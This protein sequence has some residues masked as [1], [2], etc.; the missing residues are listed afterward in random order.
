ML[1]DLDASFVCPPAGCQAHAPPPGPQQ[2]CGQVNIK[3][4]LA[5]AAGAK[6]A[7]ARW[8]SPANARP[9]MCTE[10]AV[11]FPIDDWCNTGGFR[12]EEPPCL[13]K[14]EAGSLPRNPRG[15]EAVVIQPSYLDWGESALC[16]CRM[17]ALRRS[18]AVLMGRTHLPLTCHFVA[19]PCSAMTHKF[20]IYNKAVQERLWI[21]SV[22][23]DEIQFYPL[24]F[25]RLEVPP[26]G[27][28]TLS[29]VYLPRTLGPVDAS[30]VVETSR[31]SFLVPMHG[32]GVPSPYGVT[33]LSGPKVPGLPCP[34]L[35]APS[36]GS[37]PL[38]LKCRLFPCWGQVPF[39]LYYSYMLMLRNPHEKPLR[40]KEVYTHNS[41]LQLRLPASP[42]ATGALSTEGRVRIL[43]FLL[44]ADLGF[45]VELLGPPAQDVPGPS[46]LWTIEPFAEKGVIMLE[47]KSLLPQKFSGMVTVI[48][49][50]GPLL[51]P[52]DI[53]AIKGGVHANMDGVD[54]GAPPASPLDGSQAFGLPSC[55]WRFSHNAAGLQLNRDSDIPRGASQ[56]SCCAPQ[57][58]AG[59][60]SAP[61]CVFLR[62]GPSL[63][64]PV[65]EGACAGSGR[66]AHCRNNHVHWNSAG[67]GYWL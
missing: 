5:S 21:T 31:G 61:G 42:G 63:G 49:D 29:I 60:C 11:T 3:L 57:H 66:R 45:G 50:E 32:Q 34:H 48:T 17:E 22:S 40:V 19:M 47:F 4:R 10:T 36:S 20:Q 37:T 53:S 35:S 13:T 38:G 62:L 52:V 12:E 27:G 56:H 46:H 6:I 39:G 14:A 15:E 65:P 16:R 2:S 28:A 18:H 43:T 24:D 59:A 58:G 64:H 41:F 1:G 23:T 7:R 51:I 55:I 54:F 44:A 33:P 8:H 67:E 9:P 25:E 30:L 26:G